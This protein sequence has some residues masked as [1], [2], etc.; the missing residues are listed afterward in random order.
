VAKVPAG[1]APPVPVPYPNIKAPSS[2]GAEKQSKQVGE[3]R[4][5]EQKLGT[6]QMKAILSGKL[7]KAP[8]F[9]NAPTPKF[10]Q[11][12]PQTVQQNLSAIGKSLD[13]AN[14]KPTQEKFGSVV[15]R[16]ADKVGQ[17]EINGLVHHVLKE[18]Y[19][20]MKTDLK[21]YSD[22]AKHINETKKKVRE[23]I[24]NART[25]GNQGLK[26][27]KSLERKLATVGDD[28]QLANVDLQNI[29]QKQQQ[30]LQS[31]SN[32]SKQ[33]HDTATSILRKLGG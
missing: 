19:M 33:L 13:P 1:P 10:I 2:P 15:S 22:K 29:L 4:M 32:I 21:H 31:M 16:M 23:E 27:L 12:L 24:Q 17:N 20:E 3:S 11:S 6:Q 26:T 7:P 8:E 9:L 25:L 5:G 30:L 18:S 14:L 28:A